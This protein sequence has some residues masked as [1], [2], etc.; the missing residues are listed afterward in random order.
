[1][2]NE[3]KNVLLVSTTG[4][5]SLKAQRRPGWVTTLVLHKISS[6]RVPYTLVPC[7]VDVDAV[8]E[9]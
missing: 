2:P 1:M 5:Q 3:A 9:G 4:V 6:T 8:L 7:N